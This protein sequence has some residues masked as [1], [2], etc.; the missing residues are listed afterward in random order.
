MKLFIFGVGREYPNGCMWRA[1]AR[2]PS[3]AVK[4]FNSDFRTSFSM[5]DFVVF[6]SEQEWN[7]YKMV[8]EK[9]IQ[10][11]EEDVFYEVPF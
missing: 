8:L 10:E 1:Y 3:E 4:K 7:D 9:L 11:P 6:N 5:L 2:K